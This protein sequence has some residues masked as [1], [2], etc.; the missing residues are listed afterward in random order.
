LALKS[1]I[2]FLKYTSVFLLVG[3]YSCN[4]YKQV[5]EGSSVLVSNRIDLVGQEKD[6]IND[7]FY[8][9]EIYKIPTQKPNAKVFGIPLSQHIWAFYNK[10]KVTQ[11][12]Q[13]MKTKV[14]KSPLLF[15]STKLERSR[16][17][18]ENYYFNIGHLDNKV[19]VSYQTRAKRTKVVY[20]IEPKTPY[21][22]R[23]LFTDTLTPIQ[24]DISA[25]NIN[26]LVV[27]N[28]ILN[29]ETLEREIGRMAFVANNKG[30]YDFTKDN[31]KYR[32]DTFHKKHEVDIYVKILEE[33]DT[34]VF[35]KFNR[36]NHSRVI[37]TDTSVTKSFKNVSRDVRRTRI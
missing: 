1:T 24:K 23:A 10:R 22:I 13:F 7:F 6:L 28:E 31:I 21:K 16:G 20:T 17:A 26:S 18:L 32:F 3:V 4:I 34:T 37:A 9:D 25:E 8:K 2:N 12:S 11:F 30:Y 19:N 15:D 36:S 5:P 14:G 27:K 35:Q 29:I 33:S